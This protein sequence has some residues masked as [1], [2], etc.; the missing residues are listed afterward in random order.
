VVF[1]VVDRARRNP[2][3]VY[4]LNRSYPVIFRMEVQ[5]K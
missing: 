2:T 5:S 1:A 4:N 3:T